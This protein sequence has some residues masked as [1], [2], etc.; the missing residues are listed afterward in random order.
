M[1]D[2][3][4]I[5]GGPAGLSAAVQARA[6]GKSVTVY[7]NDIHRNWLCRTPLVDNYLGLPGISGKEM[8][9]RFFDHAK[10]AGAQVEEKR[11]TSVLPMGKTF[12][13]SAGSQVMEAQSII[14]AMG[15]AKS[16]QIPGE[17]QLMG[18][19]VSTCATCDGML[20]RGK[21][22]LVVAQSPLALED[23]IFLY[24]IGCEVTVV[25]PGGRTNLEGLPETIPVISGSKLA[26]EGADHAVGLTVDRILYPADCVFLIRDTSAPDAL[27]PGLVLDS[28]FIKTARDQSTSIP[29]VFAAGDCTGLPLQVGKAVGEG[30]TAALSAISWLA[31]R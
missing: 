20:Y 29:G 5:G 1:T 17:Q 21:R 12:L 13:L 15:A 11:I 2:I 23:S 28:G 18:K 31:S 10:R 16:P 26:L 30:L 14:L 25:N 3:A 27:V 8:M 24:E 19:G 7:T 22:V 4:I 6:R 9:E